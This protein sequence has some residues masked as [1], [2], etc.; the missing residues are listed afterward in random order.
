MSPS[1][2]FASLR[3]QAWNVPFRGLPGFGRRSNGN[4]SKETEPGRVSPVAGP[5]RNRQRV[6]DKLRPSNAAAR[7]GAP[8]AMADLRS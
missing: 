5:R 8:R 6:D 1:R 7:H 2:A 4:L 3:T